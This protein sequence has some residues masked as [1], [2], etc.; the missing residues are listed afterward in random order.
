MRLMSQVLLLIIIATH[1]LHPH[2]GSFLRGSR[3]RGWRLQQFLEPRNSNRLVLP[4]FREEPI[5]DSL[6]NLPTELLVRFELHF[7]EKLIGRGVVRELHMSH[8]ILSK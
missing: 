8:L 4:L 2:Y 5:A 3:S 6:A 1:R 7:V